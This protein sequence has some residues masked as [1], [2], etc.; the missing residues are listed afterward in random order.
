M[1]TVLCF[2]TDTNDSHVILASCCTLD[3][4]LMSVKNGV[5]GVSTVT[6][7]SSITDFYSMGIDS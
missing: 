5:Q 1:T 2:K 6:S 3:Y 4:G 7:S